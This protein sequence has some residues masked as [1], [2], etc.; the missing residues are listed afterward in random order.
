MAGSYYR[1]EDFPDVQRLPAPDNFSYVIPVDY[2]FH[3][4]EKPFCYDPECDC[5]ED[6]V[7]NFQVSLHVAEGLMT[8]DEATDFVHGRG[9]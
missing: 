6:E 1:A 3:T 8:P 7:A 9:I 4:P 2:L 5:H